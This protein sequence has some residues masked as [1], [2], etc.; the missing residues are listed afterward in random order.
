MRKKD[1][2]FIIPLVV[3]PFDIMVS[4][5]QTDDELKKQLNKYG[6]DKEDECWKYE[7]PREKGRTCLFNTNQTLIRMPKVP[8]M[9]SEYAT[10]QHEIFHSVEFLFERIGIKHST[11]CGETYAY[12]IGY[13]TEFIYE[14]INKSK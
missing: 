14:K 10:L 5:G 9:C 6:I 8:K 2:N 3:Y 11:D 4:F 12:L 13:I 7:T 1:M